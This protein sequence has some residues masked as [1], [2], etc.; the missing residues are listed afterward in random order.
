[1]KTLHS[2]SSLLLISTLFVTNSYPQLIQP[3]Q[4]LDVQFASDSIVLDGNPDEP[5]YS[6]EQATAI[7]NPAGYD[8]SDADF[9]A[10][11]KLAYDMTNL[12]LWAHLNDDIEEN[13][14]WELSSPWMFDNVEVFL[15]L[16][17]CTVPT[18][19]NSRT[20]Q[21][22]FCRGLD[23][24]QEPGR[25]HRSDFGYYGHSTSDSWMLETAIPWTSVL[26]DGDD[27]AQIREYLC[28]IG[29][30]FSGADS[31]NSDGDLAVGNR[32]CQSAWD[33]D[34]PDDAAD[35]TEDNAWN[36]T[37]VFGRLLL[38][39][40]CPQAIPGQATASEKYQ[41]CPYPNP[42]CNTLKMKNI[43]TMS[44]VTVYNVFGIKLLEF[45]KVNPE[46]ELDISTLKSGLYTA[47]INNKEAVRFV[48]E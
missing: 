9:K 45:Y 24:V 38:Y 39:A 29:F 10:V 35:R 44:E 23:S 2:F 48:K 11:F 42:C 34:L 5:E 32:D 41:L 46:T 12:Y 19:Y 15:Q 1:M 6:A 17:T 31:D 3:V 7:F 43:T 40:T 16:D 8:G 20:V 22:R 4:T 26:A 25:A 27:P 13:Y 14:S 30:D 36:N 28:Y 21:L 47:V 33:S 18:T 37:S